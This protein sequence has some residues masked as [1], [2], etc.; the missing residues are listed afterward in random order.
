MALLNSLVLV[1][2][3]GL[4][5][6]QDKE[7]VFD[8]LAAV[9]VKLCGARLDVAAKPAVV[10]DKSDPVTP[11]ETDAVEIKTVPAPSTTLTDKVFS[12]TTCGVNVALLLKGLLE[13]LLYSA[14]EPVVK[15]LLFDQV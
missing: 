2:P 5:V 4:V 8:P 13:K 11:M 10:R 1:E 12:P 3:S 7:Y 14:V 6:D 15:K 9:A